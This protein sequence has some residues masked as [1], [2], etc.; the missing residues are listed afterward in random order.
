MYA[1]DLINYLRECID[2]AESQDINHLKVEVHFQKEWPLKGQITDVK[3]IDDDTIA[4]TV[5]DLW[6]KQ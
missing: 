5:D 4:I 3:L 1:D 6:W 2:N